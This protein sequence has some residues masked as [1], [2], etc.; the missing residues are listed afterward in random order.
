[1]LGYTAWSLLDNFEWETGY[2]E[3][4]GLHYI[5]YS[6]PNLTRVP[7]ASAR[8]MAK[9]IA[10]NGFPPDNGSAPGIVGGFRDRMYLLIGALFV[11][12]CIQRGV[13]WK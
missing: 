8:F 7:K 13:L 2:T 6:D 10:D 5:N 1:M 3:R 9:I 4:F 12:L 11:M